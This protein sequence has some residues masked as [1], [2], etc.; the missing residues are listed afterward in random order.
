M[1]RQPFKGQLFA[2]GRCYASYQKLVAFGQPVLGN[3]R[4][5][6]KRLRYT[7]AYLWTNVKINFRSEYFGP[8]FDG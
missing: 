4:G 7:G 6:S 5:A 2:Q 1:Q 8:L 3:E